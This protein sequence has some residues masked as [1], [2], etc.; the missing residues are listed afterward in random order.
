MAGSA[1]NTGCSWA[2]A[3]GQRGADGLE[4]APRDVPGNTRDDVCNDNSNHTNRNRSE[5]EPQH[6]R[7]QRHDPALT[8][9]AT[10]QHASPV[11]VLLLVLDLNFSAAP[12]YRAAP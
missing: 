10:S 12:I 6:S 7:R 4:Q 3:L 9:R 8:L 1:N 2:T 5:S 11:A